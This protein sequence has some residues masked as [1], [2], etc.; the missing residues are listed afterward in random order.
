MADAPKVGQIVEHH[1]LWLAEHSSGQFEGRKR[2]PCLIVAVEERG[3]SA[4][5]VTLL[6]ITSQIPRQGISALAI[7]RELNARIGLDPKRDAWLVLDEANV[8]TWPGFDLVPQRSGEYAR[9][10]VTAGF[11]TLV[12]NTLIA[13]RARGR[14][15]LIE[16]DD[17]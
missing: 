10:N 2:R 4:P 9:G 5:R 7:P 1:F 13:M 8:F 15:K 12:R 11:F 17:G 14:P 16:R 6:P 3:E